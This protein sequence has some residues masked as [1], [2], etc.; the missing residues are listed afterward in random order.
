MKAKD[1]TISILCTL[2]FSAFLIFVCSNKL[3]NDKPK[4]V[5]EV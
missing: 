5:Y 1:I 2:I 3:Q 4:D